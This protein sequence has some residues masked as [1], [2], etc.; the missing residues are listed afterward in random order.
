M[1]RSQPSS[2]WLE[3]DKLDAVRGAAKQVDS[4]KEKL[5]CESDE[6]SVVVPLTATCG[7]TLGTHEENGP[8]ATEKVAEEPQLSVEYPKGITLFFM[9]LALVLTITLISLDQVSFTTSG[10]SLAIY[11]SRR[12]VKFFCPDHCC[13]RR[14]KDH[15]HFQ[16]NSGHL[17]V[18]FGIFPHAG[19]IPI[20]VG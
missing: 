5:R 1:S 12:W 15:R 3:Q 9:M 8:S 18:W 13:D 14:P 4:E 19:S 7:E 17:L 2:S 16:Q 11:A 20:T 6:L 10:S